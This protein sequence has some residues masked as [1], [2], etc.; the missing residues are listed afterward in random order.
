MN[1]PGFQKSKASIN[2]LFVIILPSC[3]WMNDADSKTTDQWSRDLQ[4]REERIRFVEKY[5]RAPSQ[6][7]DTEFHIIYHDNSTGMVPGPSDWR[8][9]AAFKVNPQDAG[10]WREGFVKTDGKDAD[11]G[12]W[13]DVF[14][15][16][17]FWEA[18]SRP[19]F[20]RRENAM[21]YVVIYQKEGIVLKYMTSEY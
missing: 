10:K 12:L 7:L 9:V 17:N 3:N 21:V 16:D 19:E 14:P 8:I 4:T 6:I 18:S 20:Y 13:R 11:P 2:L 15:S 1:M 5:I